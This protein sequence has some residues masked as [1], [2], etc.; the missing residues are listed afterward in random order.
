[1]TSCTVT[2]LHEANIAVKSQWYMPETSNPNEHTPWPI[3]T[4]Q[5]ILLQLIFA[6]LVAKQE[7]TLNLNLRFQLPDSKYE[8]LTSLVQTCRRLGLFNY[9]NMLS[10]FDPSAPVALIWVSVEELKRLGLALYK[11]CRLCARGDSTNKS[12]SS[13]SGLRNELLTL[14]DLDFCMPDSDQAWNAPP[15]SGSEWFRSIALQQTCRNNQDPGGWI[16]QTSA[17]LYDER[18]SFDWI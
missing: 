18:V 5:S 12:G 7:S 14:R 6:L 16:S 3:P 4:Y 11:L 10:R 15:G 1:M 8:L 2:L 13:S 17:S 9:P